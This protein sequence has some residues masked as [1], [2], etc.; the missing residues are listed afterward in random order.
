M[1]RMRS[2]LWF[3]IATI[4][5][6]SLVDIGLTFQNEPEGFRDLKWGDPPGEKMEF[7]GKQDEWVSIYRDPSDKLE[8]GDARF[9]MI[10]YEFYTPSDATVRRLMGVG[11]YFK[12]KENFDI[13]ETICK[14][15]F[16]ELTWE[17]FHQ[18][19]WMS[20]DSMVTLDY[21]SV[22]EEG[23]L[24]LCSTPI[25]KQFTE[26]KEKKQAEEAEKDW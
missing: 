5:V 7:L 4:L 16:G 14:V 21:E 8:L 20:L 1:K 9:Y 11:L 12:D 24:G 26:E 6:F 17:R 19:A 13:L 2:L 10:L 18:L 15:K 25:F 22:K 23:N 3:L